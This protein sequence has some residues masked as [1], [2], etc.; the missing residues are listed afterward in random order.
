MSL[1]RDQIINWIKKIDITNKTVLDVGSGGDPQ[2]YA[3]TWTK[4]IGKVYMTAD[5]N[6][7]FKPDIVI[8][9]DLDRF[10]KDSDKFEV[11]FCLETLEHCWN[12]LHAIKTLAD[13]TKEVLYIS[14]PFINP[15][16]DTWDYLRYTGKWF[17]KVLPQFGFKSV[18]VESRKASDLGSNFLTSFYDIEGM[19]I[20]KIRLKKGEGHKINDVGYLITARK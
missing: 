9:L 2:R 12:P 5:I 18:E 8:D 4:G 17:K 20:S 19:R 7:K 13:V 15:I 14:T 10:R 3:N 1:K 11:V 6:N 16:H